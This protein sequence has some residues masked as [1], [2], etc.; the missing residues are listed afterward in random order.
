[1]I[2]LMTLASGLAWLLRRRGVAELQAGIGTAPQPAPKPV[3]CTSQ[4]GEKEGERTDW[5]PTGAT[6]RHTGMLS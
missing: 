3:L 4:G 1:M 6:D 2:T 5:I